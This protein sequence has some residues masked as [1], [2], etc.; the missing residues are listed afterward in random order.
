[1]TQPQQP[2]PPV[3]ISVELTYGMKIEERASI[4]P[5]YPDAP[6]IIERFIMVLTPAF[7]FELGPFSDTKWRQFVD[8]ANDPQGAQ[9]RAAAL[10]KLHIPGQDGRLN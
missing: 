2:L 3:K 5:D 6:P 10:S 1:M 9:E 8:M 7:E 4:D